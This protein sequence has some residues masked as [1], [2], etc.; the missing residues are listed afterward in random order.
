MQANDGGTSRS[1]EGSLAPLT[2]Q[3]DGMRM[4]PSDQH[5]LG[6]PCLPHHLLPWGAWATPPT[7]PTF[8]EGR[9]ARP[10]RSQLD[11]PPVP[12]Q[13]HE[14]RAASIVHVGHK[15]CMAIRLGCGK[16]IS[17]HGWQGRHGEPCSECLEPPDDSQHSMPY[18]LRQGSHEGPGNMLSDLRC[19]CSP[20]SHR[21]VSQHRQ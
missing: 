4:T 6:T 13:H 18:P 21:S 19:G 9:G 10:S 8:R 7:V 11:D 16:A 17:V 12:C 20:R 14:C 5:P 15:E 1:L 2:W 3:E